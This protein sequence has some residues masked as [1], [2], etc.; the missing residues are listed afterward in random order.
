MKRLVV[1]VVEQE[2]KFVAGAAQTAAN[3][4]AFT[5]STED[6]MVANLSFIGHKEAQSSECL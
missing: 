4:R 1:V 5:H 2:T 3:L 6:F